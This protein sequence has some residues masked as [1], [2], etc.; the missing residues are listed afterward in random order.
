MNR[1]LL[2][3]V[4]GPLALVLLGVSGLAIFVGFANMP[5]T[6]EGVRYAPVLAFEGLFA[7]VM[8][9]APA[10]LNAVEGRIVRSDTG[11]PIE[12]AHVV[13]IDSLSDQDRPS[14]VNTDDRG[15]FTV[16][17]ACAWGDTPLEVT[18]PG[19]YKK[20]ATRGDDPGYPTI[21]LIPLAR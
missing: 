17:T 8:L 5:Q 18:A 19:Y 9:V 4:V 16:Y 6:R 7:L 11:Q 10:E 21:T 15:E 2:R 14:A 1:S 20:V 3:R 12:G 13:A